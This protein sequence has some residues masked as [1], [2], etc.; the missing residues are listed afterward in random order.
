MGYLMD[1]KINASSQEAL[2]HMF[3]TYNDNK[4]FRIRKIEFYNIFYRI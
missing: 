1:N 4:L 2:Y 3:P